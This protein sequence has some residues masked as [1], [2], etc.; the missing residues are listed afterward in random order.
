MI[1]VYEQGDISFSC[2]SKVTRDLLSDRHPVWVSEGMLAQWKDY[3]ENGGEWIPGEVEHATPM[4]VLT[5]KILLSKSPR[6]MLRII[7]KHDKGVYV[8]QEEND[9]LKKAGL[10]ST[11][12]E[13]GTSWR[14]RYAVVKIKVHPHLVKMPTALV[15]SGGKVG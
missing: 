8:T 12:P 4:N 3:Q 11:F 15:P 2:V 13:G 9:R 14:D 5:E 10:E 7:D 6:H 1:Q